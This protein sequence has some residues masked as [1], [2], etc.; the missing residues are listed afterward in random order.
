MDM[1]TALLVQCQQ[2]RELTSS[3]GAVVTTHIFI[4]N[5]RIG[6]ISLSVGPR[7]AFRA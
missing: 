1:L 2:V 7:Q 4:Y 5:L 3:S 6:Q